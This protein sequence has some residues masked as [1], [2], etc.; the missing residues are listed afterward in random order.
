MSHIPFYYM[1]TFGAWNQ[2]DSFS[3]AMVARYL[4]APN[5]FRPVILSTQRYNEFMEKLTTNREPLV[6]QAAMQAGLDASVLE[7]SIAR[8]TLGL[9]VMPSETLILPGPY[10]P[11]GPMPISLVS[12]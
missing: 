11:C 8:S 2:R 1:R 4:L 6:F 7:A 9:L 12:R 5:S 3:D 10:A